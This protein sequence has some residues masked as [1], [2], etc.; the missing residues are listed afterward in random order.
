MRVGFLIVEYYISGIAEGFGGPGGFAL[1]VMR[2]DGD[3]WA[4]N[5]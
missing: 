2:W 3:G 1:C 5:E 4:R